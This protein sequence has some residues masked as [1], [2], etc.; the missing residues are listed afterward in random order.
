MAKRGTPYI[1]EVDQRFSDAETNQG[2]PAGGSTGQVLTKDSGTDGDASWHT[3]STTTVAQTIQTDAGTYPVMDE[4]DTLTLYNPDTRVPFTGNSGQKKVTFDTSALL[5]TVPPA[6]LTGSE[7]AFSGVSGQIAVSAT[8]FVM[9]KF[10]QGANSA[11]RTCTVANGTIA[12]QRVLFVGGSDTYLVTFEQ[13]G[14]LKINGDKVLG[15]YSRLDIIW[16]G[17]YWYETYSTV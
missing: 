3:P 6:V 2:V 5:S 14:N 4:N 15:A 8:D 10:I 1:P 16:S 17:T 12:G 11:P 13:A 7:A 9:L